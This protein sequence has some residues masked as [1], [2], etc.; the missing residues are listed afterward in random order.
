M[1]LPFPQISPVTIEIANFLIVNLTN[2]LNTEQMWTIM[3]DDTTTSKDITTKFMLHIDIPICLLNDDLPSNQTFL[4]QQTSATI[5]LINDTDSQKLHLIVKKLMRFEMYN[6]RVETVFVITSKVEDQN[7]LS[8]YLK[9]IWSYGI[10][11][12]LVAFFDGNIKSFSYNPF[13][14]EIREVLTHG[15]KPEFP[16]YLTNLEGYTLKVAMFM[17]WPRVQRRKG[18]LIGPDVMLLENLARLLNASLSIVETSKS[19]SYSG[20]YRSVLSSQSD[21][22]FVKYF[23]VY[24]E[25]PNA[26]YTDPYE[27]NYVDVYVPN[28]RP[29]PTYLTVFMVFN[30]LKWITIGLTFLTVL[31]SFKILSTKSDRNKIWSYCDIFMI[32]LCLTLGIPLKRLDKYPRVLKILLLPYIVMIFIFVVDFRSHLLNRFQFTSYQK[33]ITTLQELAESGIPLYT[34]VNKTTSIPKELK[35][36]YHIYPNLEFVSSRKTNGTRFA[37]A[38]PFLWRRNIP[39]K[40]GTRPLEYHSIHET[41]MKG[42]GIYMFRKNSPYVEKFNQL[43]VNIRQF[44]LSSSKAIIGVSDPHFNNKNSTNDEHRKLTMS[45][46]LSVF[47]ILTIGLLLSTITFIFEVYMQK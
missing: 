47:F 43:M 30:S 24:G 18:K 34:F 9:I 39:M 16:N 45:E 27:L 41:L 22:C 3:N 12:Y 28:A 13:R 11:R 42:F 5:I 35:E 2:L 6:S 46:V 23:F 20:A 33:G 19:D 17:Q 21:L 10:I 1:T 25:F 14:N 40:P 8:D 15:E 37:F 44:G 29:L 26:E 36:Q 4:Q 7:F 31:V 32:M 38:L